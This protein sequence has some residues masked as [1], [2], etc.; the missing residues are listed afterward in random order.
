MHAYINSS[1]VRVES[2]DHSLLHSLHP[3]HVANAFPYDNE[4]ISQYVL[5]DVVF[6]KVS[7]NSHL[8]SKLRD[9][10]N[11]L[12]TKT[13]STRQR[14]LRPKSPKV[15]ELQANKSEAGNQPTSIGPQP[16]GLRATKSVAGQDL[17][18]LRT[19][20]EDPYSQAVLAATIRAPPRGQK[21]KK[22]V[23]NEARRSQEGQVQKAVK[24]IA[25]HITPPKL[26]IPSLLPGDT[27]SI[28]VNP[29]TSLFSPPA[30]PASA[31]FALARQ[32]WRGE[33]SK[34]VTKPRRRWV[35]YTSVG[36]VEV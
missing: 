16:P 9:A 24:P 23:G 5:H 7:F 29:M 18:R 34:N 17:N 4:H 30:A 22:T 20:I 11:F 13:T 3:E 26:H 36:N 21:K 14:S 10:P 28:L 1:S 8:Q 19:N 33:L 6:G 15:H 35:P 31:F 25:A 2:V 32:E 27:Q 12:C